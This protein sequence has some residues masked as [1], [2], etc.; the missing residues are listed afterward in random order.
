MSLHYIN[1]LPKVCDQQECTVAF[2]LYDTRAALVVYEGYREFLSTPRSF[3]VLRVQLTREAMICTG[4]NL[5]TDFQWS[6]LQTRDYGLYQVQDSELS[7]AD[8]AHHWICHC[9]DLTLEFC[10]E[11]VTLIGTRYH[12]SSVFVALQQAL[13]ELSSENSI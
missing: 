12:Q 3:V 13:N 4:G 8:G 7:S 11:A 10:A 1:T 5:L 2:C 6:E 9:P